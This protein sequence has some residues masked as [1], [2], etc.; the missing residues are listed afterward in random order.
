MAVSLSIANLPADIIRC[1]ADRAATECRPLLR[2]ACSALR[3]AVPAE[4]QPWILLQPRPSE[5]NDDFSVLS[6]PADVKL[7]SPGCSVAPRNLAMAFPPG[8]RRVGAGHGW[9]VGVPR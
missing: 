7:L 8:A 2:A 1:I 6:L 4:P 5:D 9:V 3:A